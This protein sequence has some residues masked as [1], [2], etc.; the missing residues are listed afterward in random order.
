MSERYS[1]EARLRS[2]PKLV[3][4]RRGLDTI[5]IRCRISHAHPFSHRTLGRLIS[6]WKFGLGL[7]GG[8]VQIKPHA[9][10]L[11]FESS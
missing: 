10:P 7:D 6:S 2:D 4:V 5:P 9:P 8:D 11:P 3:V 1:I